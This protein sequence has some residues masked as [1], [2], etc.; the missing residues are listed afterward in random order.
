MWTRPSRSSKLRNYALDESTKETKALDSILKESK[1]SQPFHSTL[2]PNKDGKKSFE[3]IKKR[4]EEGKPGGKST[5]PRVAGDPAI[6]QG[7]D[8]AAAR[9]EE[10]EA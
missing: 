1:Y 9:A 3:A 4:I 7:A 2:I 5:A 6:G 10:A 8:E